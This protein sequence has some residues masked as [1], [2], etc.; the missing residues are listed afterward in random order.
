ME[1]K[2]TT[3]PKIIHYCWFGGNPLPESALKCIAS[4]KRH[5]PGYEI[6]QWDESNFDVNAITYTQEAYESKKYAFVSDYARF[7]ILKQYGGVYFDTDV[8]VIKPFDDILSRGGFM[9]IEFDHFVNPGLGCAAEKGNA[10]FGDIIE[11]YKGLHYKDSDGNKLPGTVVTHTTDVLLQ[12][13]YTKDATLPVTIGGITIYAYD[14]FNPLEDATGKMRKTANTHSIHWY[15][16]T[17]ISGYG[18]MRTRFTRL[19]HRIIGVERSQQIKR[20]L[21]LG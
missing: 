1:K 11:Y 3:I 10:L 12:N 20:L 9:G 19:L 16:K 13:G 17:W 8:E 6:K 4:W 5:F 21:G 18:S 2:V 7:V 15:S 14:Y